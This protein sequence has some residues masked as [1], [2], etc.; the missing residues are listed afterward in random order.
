VNGIPL[1]ATTAVPLLE[2]IDIGDGG[3]SVKIG[4]V[5]R[6]ARDVEARK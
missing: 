3:A 5:P 6:R 1:A 4:R 2:Q